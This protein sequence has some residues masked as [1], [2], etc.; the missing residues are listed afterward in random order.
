MSSPAYA[1]IHWNTPTSSTQMAL[2]LYIGIWNISVLQWDHS[3]NNS[4]PTTQ[5]W[6]KDV[7]NSLQCLQGMVSLQ[8]LSYYTN[9]FWWDTFQAVKR[10]NW[11][12][13]DMHLYCQPERCMDPEAKRKCMTGKTP[14]RYLTKE[15]LRNEATPSAYNIL[16]IASSPPKNSMYCG[17]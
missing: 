13:C 1:H 15:Q 12:Q 8:D 9:C 3:G 2:I 14:V 4:V 11:T 6:N 7:W 16:F 17:N 5:L 10:N